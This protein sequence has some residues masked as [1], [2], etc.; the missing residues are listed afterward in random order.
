MQNV[1][2]GGR[3]KPTS[4]LTMTVDVPALVF[5]TFRDAWIVRGPD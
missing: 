5:T 4:S 2:E 3:E 1:V